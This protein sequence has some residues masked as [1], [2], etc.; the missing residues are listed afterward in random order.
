M[1]LSP[2]SSFTETH[3]AR[4]WLSC[5]CFTIQWNFEV[6]KAYIIQKIL[7]SG[8]PAERIVAGRMT[9]Q[10]PN[11]FVQPFTDMFNSVMT[12]DEGLILDKNDLVLFSQLQHY[13]RGLHQYGLNIQGYIYK[14]FVCGCAPGD[15]GTIKQKITATSPVGTTN[16][17]LSN[18]RNQQLLR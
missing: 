1:L 4:F 11:Y 10:P 9:S 18:G 5:L 6:Q 3:T 16:A 2:G 15:L 12:L 13:V 14:I 8:S 17:A 7:E